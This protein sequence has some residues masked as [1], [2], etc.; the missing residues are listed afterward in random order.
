MHGVNNFLHDVKIKGAKFKLKNKQTKTYPRAPK[1][2]SV[3][4]RFVIWVLLG[5]Q[6]STEGI[7]T[8]ACQILQRKPRN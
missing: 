3:A 5:R 7:S 4:L 2:A 1:G 6:H 8:G